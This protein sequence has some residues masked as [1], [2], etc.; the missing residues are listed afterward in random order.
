[1]GGGWSP[2]RP[3]GTGPTRLGRDELGSLRNPFRGKPRPSDDDPEEDD[4]PHPEL[5]DIGAPTPQG[6]LGLLH[7]RA[8]VRELVRELNA[9]SATVLTEYRGLTTQHLR[10]LRTTLGEDVSYNVVK[11][12]LMRRAVVAARVPLDEALLTG[13]TAIAFVKGDVVSAARKL[14]EFAEH[15]PRLVIKGGVVEG[16]I[17]TPED[18]AEVASL[19]SREELLAAL[20]GQ[21]RRSIGSAAGVMRAPTGVAASLMRSFEQDRRSSK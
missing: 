8:A 11:N 5:P 3:R 20:A 19:G 21:M 1:M 13:P 17:L 16:Q 4:G 7:K 6:S 9:S 14:R 2:G 18:L 15:E 12:T 10:V